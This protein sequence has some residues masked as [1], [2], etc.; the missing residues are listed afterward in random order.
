M[1]SN[2]GI[3]RSFI[4]IWNKIQDHQFYNGATSSNPGPLQCVWP[5]VS[6]HRSGEGHAPVGRLGES[7]DRRGG[8][9]RGQDRSM[10]RDPASGWARSVD[11]WNPKNASAEAAVGPR[12]TEGGREIQLGDG[13]CI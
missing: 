3:N 8:I 12:A 9:H 10:A 5:S 1:T 7:K 4:V 2:Q 13:L 6:E 11:G